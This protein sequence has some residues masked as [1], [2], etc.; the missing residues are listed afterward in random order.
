MSTL[1]EENKGTKGRRS[2]QNKEYFIVNTKEK[3]YDEKNIIAHF[4]MD[5]GIIKLDHKV[6]GSAMKPAPILIPAAAP[7]HVLFS[8]TASPEELLSEEQ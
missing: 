7:Y 3:I 1:P 8:A 2:T 6:T 4:S 5:D